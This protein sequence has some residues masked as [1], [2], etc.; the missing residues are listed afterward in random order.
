MKLPVLSV[1]LSLSALALLSALLIVDAKANND[2]AVI[3]AITK[4]ENDTVQADL[5][6]D[7][8]F[9]EKLL[10]GDWTFGDSGG[11]WMTKAELL[12]SFAERANTKTSFEKISDLKVRVYGDAA[13]ATY[14]DTFA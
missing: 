8:P 14:R 11:F 1:T 12:K 13:V 10:A 3:A 6:N 2:L 9:F 7:R 4:I 5:A